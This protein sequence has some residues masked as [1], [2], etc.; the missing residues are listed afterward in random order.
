V[1]HLDGRSEDCLSGNAGFDPDNGA[2]AGEC[3]LPGK[4][5]VD[6]QFHFWRQVFFCKEQNSGMADINRF[7][8]LPARHAAFAI[9]N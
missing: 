4:G 5:N 7:T 1:I 2:L 8:L 6:L 3:G 9:V